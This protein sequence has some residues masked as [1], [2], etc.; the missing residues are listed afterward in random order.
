MAVNIFKQYYN[1]VPQNCFLSQ[2][3]QDYYCVREYVGLLPPQRKKLA[4]ITPNDETSKPLIVISDV[5]D[6]LSDFIF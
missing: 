4:K 5:A 1:N 3:I 6:F 2:K